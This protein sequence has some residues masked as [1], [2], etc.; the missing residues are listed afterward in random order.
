MVNYIDND[1][2]I[3]IALT[4]VSAPHSGEQAPK[5]NK[6][7]YSSLGAEDLVTWFW[8]LADLERTERDIG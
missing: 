7:Y 1:A 2:L 6:G 4:Y 5:S 8:T 3:S